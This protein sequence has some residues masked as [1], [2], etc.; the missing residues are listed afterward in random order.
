MR[1]P[2]LRTLSST[3]AFAGMAAIALAASCSAPKRG[4]PDQ[5]RIGDAMQQAADAS[6]VREPFDDQARLAVLRQR[7]IF[8]HH[9]EPFSTHLTPLGERDLQILAAAMRRDGG[10][11]SLPRGS[12]SE[13]LHAA[14]VL[15]VRAA[16]EADGIAPDRI[17]LDEGPIG[18][19]G[20]ATT[21]AILIRVRI[22]QNPLKI[23]DTSSSG[24]SSASTTTTT[25]GGS[26]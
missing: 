25:T 13:S 9:F 15:A 20:V 5:V 23:P 11:I 17:E 8:D 1:G 14:R 22:E 6:F 21:E 3:P 18:G 26:Q 10:R 4:E 12:C 24:T 16:L 2:N 19:R 7:A